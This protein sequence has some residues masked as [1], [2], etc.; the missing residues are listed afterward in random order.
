MFP[1]LSM[2]IPK[3]IDK[4]YTA[5]EL[6]C[7]DLHLADSVS[8]AP[9][10]NQIFIFASRQD[11]HSIQNSL[12]FSLPLPVHR[13]RVANLPAGRLSDGQPAKVLLLDTCVGFVDSFFNRKKRS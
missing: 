5:P 1:K 4:D 11:N 8:C 3:S 6:V 13:V 2:I 7:V 9:F 12:S 10:A